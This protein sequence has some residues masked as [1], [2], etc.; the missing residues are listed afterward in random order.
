MYI[1]GETV[2]WCGNHYLVE[3]VYQLTDKEMIDHN[4]YHRNRVTLQNVDDPSDRHDFAI[5]QA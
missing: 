4:L 2:E 3:R 1:E 5:T